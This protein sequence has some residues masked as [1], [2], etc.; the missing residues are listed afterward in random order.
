[1]G[2]KARETLTEE[3]NK[4][5][6][7]VPQ[8][9]FSFFE[10]LADHPLPPMNLEFDIELQNDADLIWQRDETDR[11]IVVRKLALSSHF[12]IHRR[13]SEDHERKR[14]KP[15]RIKYLRENL[16]SSTIMRQANG[17]WLIYPGTK[18]RKTCVCVHSANKKDQ[19]TDTEPLFC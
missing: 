8:N 4:V 1:M 16:N 6:T 5:Q 7:M 15:R 12:E 18:K 9:R 11:R 13:R 17:E 14:L 3:R 19:L 2:I 10:E